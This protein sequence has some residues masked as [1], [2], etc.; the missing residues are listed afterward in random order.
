MNKTVVRTSLIKIGNSDVICIPPKM[1]KQ[2]G[3]DQEVELEISSGYLI[4]RPV[5]MAKKPVRQGWSEQFR[6]MA[7]HGDDHLLDDTV[8]LTDWDETEW[9]W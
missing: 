6:L 1:L 9:T 2:L 3:L 4:I 7:E 8:T 5:N